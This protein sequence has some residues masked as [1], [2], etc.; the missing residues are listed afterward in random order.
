[1]NKFFH[2][3]HALSKAA[4]ESGRSVAALLYEI[5]AL[6]FSVGRI[7]ASEYFEFRLHLTDMPFAAKARFGGFRLQAALEEMLVDDYSKFLSIDKLTMYALLKGYGLP[8]PEIRASFGRRAPA[9]TLPSLMSTAELVAFLAVPENLPVYAKPAFGSY[10]RGNLLIERR[11]GESYRLGNGTM[12]SGDELAAMMPSI[13]GLGWLLQEPLESHHDITA[14]CGR[15]ISGVR[16]HTFLATTGPVITKVVWKINVGDQDSDNFRDGQSGNMAAAI[17][18]ETGIVHR[19]ING[20]GSSQTVVEF[21]VASSE[22]G[23]GVRYL[24]FQLPCWQEVRKLALNAALA[25]PGY[26]NPGWDIAICAD[27][28]RILEVNYFGDV[29]FPQHSHRQGYLDPEYMALLEGVGLAPY[30]GNAD[31]SK[32]CPVNGRSGERKCHWPW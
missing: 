14:L 1:M 32:K 13:G 15:K 18:A 20:I 17:D 16:V 26:I 24:G 19:V 12:A 23:N 22:N 8:I 9:G 10:G 25:F 3:F 30:L 21:G 28:P 27:G 2:L 11:I 31:R 7:G 5:I 29:D 4:K 6:R